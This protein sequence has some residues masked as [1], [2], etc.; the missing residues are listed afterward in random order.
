MH[1]QELTSFLGTQVLQAVNPPKRSQSFRISIKCSTSSETCSQSQHQAANPQR[2]Q[3]RDSASTRTVLPFHTA[4]KSTA[5]IASW[6]DTARPPP[7]PRSMKTI[8]LPFPTLHQPPPLPGI[9]ILVG[10]FSATLAIKN[11]VHSA[12]SKFLKV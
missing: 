5:K 12:M 7:F 4:L 3:E 2:S 10:G 8:S 1:I 11:D 6:Q 9:R